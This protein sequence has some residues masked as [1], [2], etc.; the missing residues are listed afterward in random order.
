MNLRITNQPRQ[1]YPFKGCKT[2]EDNTDSSEV[3]KCSPVKKNYK[4][5]NKKEEQTVACFKKVV[6]STVKGPHLKHAFFKNYLVYKCASC[7]L[8]IFRHQNMV[9]YLLPP[10]FDDWLCPIDKR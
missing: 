4:I 10:N 3:V 2:I 9:G 7:E 6:F 1:D 5:P 8:N